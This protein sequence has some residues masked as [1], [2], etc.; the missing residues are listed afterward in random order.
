M[1]KVWCHRKQ[2]HLFA[3]DWL[4]ASIEQFPTAGAYEM[5]LS[6]IQQ[7]F[8]LTFYLPAGW[9]SMFITF[10]WRQRKETVHSE[11]NCLLK[12]FKRTGWKQADCELPGK[13]QIPRPAPKH[14]DLAGAVQSSWWNETPIHARWG[15]A[16]QCQRSAWTGEIPRFMPSSFICLEGA[17]PNSSSM[18]LNILFTRTL[19]EKM[20]RSC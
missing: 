13:L 2:G 7:E 11:H 9:V 6:H 14:R 12:A 17:G 18:G 20:S 5:L 8:F 1:S 15:V 4:F 16:P 3:W 10:L 19:L